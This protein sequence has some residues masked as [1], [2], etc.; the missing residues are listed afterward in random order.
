MDYQVVW[1]ELALADLEAIIRR[2]A[3]DKPNAAEKLRLGLLGS[4]HV[5]G[6]FP[7][8]GPV[9][10]RD[11]SGR[12]REILHGRYRIFYRVK[13]AESR[14]EVLTIWHGG[15]QEPRLPK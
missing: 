2:V 1:T 10:E 13:E 7:F 12:T 8:I 4:V 6:Q 5:L 9:Y 3:K 11:R 14:V 15:R